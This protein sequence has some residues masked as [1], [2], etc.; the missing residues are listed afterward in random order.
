[1]KYR[2]HAFTEQGV[3]M[4]LQRASQQAGLQVNIEIGGVER[5]I[6]NT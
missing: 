1:V 6:I 4:A 5:R 2:P 3:A